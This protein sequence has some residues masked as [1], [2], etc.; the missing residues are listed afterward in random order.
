MLLSEDR[1]F[2][3]D[4]SARAVAREL[5]SEVRDLPLVCPHGHTDPAWFA[6]DAPFPDPVS[7][8]IAPDHYVVRMLYS[9]G[10]GLDELGIPR[11]GEPPAAFDAERVWATFAENYS[12]F[13]GTPT[14]MWL[15]HCFQELFGLERRLDANTAPEYFRTISDALAKPEFRPRALYE[16]FKVEVLATT[17]GALDELEH[18]DRLREDPEWK[19]RVIPTYRPD[20]VID[21]DRDGFEDN[22]EDLCAVAGTDRETWDG[23]L[24]AHRE[25]RSYFR[26]RGAVATDHGHPTAATGN[27]N[28][29]E[30]SALYSIVMSGEGT[31]SQHEAFRAQMLTEMAKMSVEDG[32]VLQLHA[33]SWRNHNESLAAAYGPDR[34]SDIPKPTDFVGGLKGLLD[35]V[36]NERGLRFVVFTLDESAYSRELA[37][38]A[39]HYPPLRLGAPWWFFDSFEGMLRYRR[40]V[41]ET[42]GFANTAGFNDDTRALLSLPARH[43]MARRA[44]CAYLA[45]LV[46]DH[47]LDA[48]EAREIAVML[49]RGLAKETYGL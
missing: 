25:R 48:D 47:R 13:R 30:A 8:F 19:G 37:P 5:Y 12:L 35:A 46:A 18:H 32:M 40:A 28:R 1:L 20:D 9:Q 22:V 4:P 11:L 16:R 7:L 43:D 6:D 39:G 36:G 42:A 23:Y 45:E 29:L 14:R 34:G 21:P 27:L 44:D 31:P 2:P 41:T 38:L 49:A 17:D 26:E 15:D 24:D 33:G 10:I 3:P